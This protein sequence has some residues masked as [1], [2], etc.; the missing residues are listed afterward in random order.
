MGKKCK[1]RKRP[2][3]GTI[4][5]AVAI[6][7]LVYY[8]IMICKE[9]HNK[10]HPA[11]YYNP[12]MSMVPSQ[13][14]T[15]GCDSP[16]SSSDAWQLPTHPSEPYIY[17]Q[18]GREV[19]RINADGS[20]VGFVGGDPSWYPNGMSP[21]LQRKVEPITSPAD[22][23]TGVN[24]EEMAKEKANATSGIT[25]N[26]QP[27][28]EGTLRDKLSESARAR[29]LRDYND[30]FR[31]VIVGDKASRQE[32][33][34]IA[35]PF[36]R[37]SNGKAVIQEYDR[38]A[39]AVSAHSHA[40]KELSEY[41]DGE[42]F[43]YIQTDDPKNNTRGIVLNCMELGRALKDLRPEISPNF[44][45][46]KAR[47]IQSASNQWMVFAAIGAIALIGALGFLTGKQNV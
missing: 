28:T 18:N 7:S 10:R 44:D 23:P 4:M 36:V 31:I 13:W 25:V 22:K 35:D 8:G 3:R 15:R 42:T 20:R 32:W 40:V 29:G 43:A 9:I 26:G 30:T 41:R 37:E 24:V 12:A 1:G 33:L 38:G 14:G 11:E 27:V 47:A 2:R 6:V 39:W 45:P 16:A 34:R 19:G 46:S 21:T 5:L 17:K